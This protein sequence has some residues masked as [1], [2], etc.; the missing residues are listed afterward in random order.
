MTDCYW[1]VKD[2]INPFLP[3]L[4]LM[5]YHRNRHVKTSIYLLD[6]MKQW[7]NWMEKESTVTVEISIATLY[8]AYYV[9]ILWLVSTWIKSVYRR[10]SVFL[11]VYFSSQFWWL[12]LGA[13][14]LLPLLWAC[15][16][17]TNDV[18]IWV[19]LTIQFLETRKQR[20]KDEELGSEYAPWGL[21]I[22]MWWKVNSY[23][24]LTPNNTTAED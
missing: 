20:K 23:V 15:G 13:C 21:P 6:D 7:R 18:G 12:L 4:L 16:K 22:Y 19:E 24:L 9:S 14:M 11:S 8:N 10:K 17:A 2:K 3:H 1:E 5:F